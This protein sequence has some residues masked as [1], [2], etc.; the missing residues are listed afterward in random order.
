LSDALWLSFLAPLLLLDSTLRGLLLVLRVAAPG[1][2]PGGRRGA[3]KGTPPRRYVVLITARDE[4]GVIGP[5]VAALRP[6]LADCPGGRLWVVAD[7]CQ[8]ATAQEAAEAG[9]RVARRD[10]G[11]ACKGAVIAWWLRSHPAEWRHDDAVVVLD[12]DSRLT[13]GGLQALTAALDH[14]DAAQAYVAPEANTGVGRQAGWSEVLMQRIDDE[15][16]RRAGWSVPLRGTGMALRAGL[17]AELAPKLHTLA[18]DLELDVLLAARGTRVE[19]VPAAV[20]V[21]P[22]PR[23]SGRAARQRAR[24]VQGHLQVLRDYW[25]ELLRAVGR[26]GA[27]DRLS[28]LMLLPLLVLRPKTLFIGL[29][30]A[31]LLTG[32]WRL[33]LAG[34]ALDAVY[35]LA[36]AGVVGDPRR[37]LLDLCAAPRY[38]AMWMWSMSLA[39]VRR[40]WLR[41]GR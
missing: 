35:Y 4:A 27:G 39:A 10:A 24:W 28:A 11:R 22:K 34:L 21:D 25:R 31:C 18:E 8:D 1:G 13:P 41:A 19:F 32:A 9:A 2:P 17:L 15:A 30:A 38:A 16:R 5:T 26:G 20:V 40:G 14:A 12:A 6:A 23:Q 29:R 37:Y 3:L 33:A 7:R 36:A